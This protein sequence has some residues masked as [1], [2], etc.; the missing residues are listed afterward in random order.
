MDY[1]SSID[2]IKRILEE[3]DAIIVEL[4]WLHKKVKKILDK[5]EISE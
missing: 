5:L 1:G 3:I 4:D 2:P